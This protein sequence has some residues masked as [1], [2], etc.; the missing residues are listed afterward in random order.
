MPEPEVKGYL[1]RTTVQLQ[2]KGAP[3]M[4]ANH[5]FHRTFL[6]DSSRPYLTSRRWEVALSGGGQW[7]S[8]ELTLGVWSIKGTDPRAV[9]MKLTR[10]AA[11]NALDREGRLR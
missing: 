8:L 5:D 1:A 4:L 2:R 9:N 3:T 11:A 7:V 10:Y 6:M